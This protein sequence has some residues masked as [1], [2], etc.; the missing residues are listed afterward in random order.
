VRQRPDSQPCS[1]AEAVATSGS[2]AI[3]RSSGLWTEAGGDGEPAVG[4]TDAEPHLITLQ[5]EA[6]KSEE[7]GRRAQIGLRG[8]AP[9]HRG[10]LRPLSLYPCLGT[11]GGAYWD[12]CPAGRAYL[13]CDR[14]AATVAEHVDLAWEPLRVRDFLF[15]LTKPGLSAPG[16]LDSSSLTLYQES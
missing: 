6:A 14:I 8:P 11:G 5:T 1:T 15:D 12:G 9:G 16:E 7:T 13:R 10:V 2:G 4:G 3:G